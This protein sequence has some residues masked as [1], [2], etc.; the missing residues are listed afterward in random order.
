VAVATAVGPAAATVTL[1]L[2]RTD[3]ASTLSVM[4]PRA[5]WSAVAKL[6]LK[7]SASNEATV[8]ATIITTSSFASTC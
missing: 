7:P 8:P 4:S 2:T 5:T 1:A 6:C 3:A